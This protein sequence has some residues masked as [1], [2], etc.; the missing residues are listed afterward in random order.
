MEKAGK[1]VGIGTRKEIQLRTSRIRLVVLL[2][3]SS[4][5]SGVWAKLS[6]KAEGRGAAVISGLH[7]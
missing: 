3:L 7:T 5:G 6:L 1:G 4:H 2:E